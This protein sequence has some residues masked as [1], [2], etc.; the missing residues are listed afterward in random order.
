MRFFYLH[1]VHDELEEPSQGAAFLLYTRI[2]FSTGSEKSSSTSQ[3]ANSSPSSSSSPTRN[4]QPSS[5]ILQESMEAFL[6][7][8]GAELRHPEGKV[9]FQK[10]S[11]GEKHTHR[12]KIQVEGLSVGS[13]QPMLPAGQ[14]D[15]GP[16]K[17]HI[18]PEPR[19]RLSGN[20]SGSF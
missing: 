2:H 11:R 10:H 7:N 1:V 8:R 14:L 20:M 17:H 16:K 13:G 9:R 4:F 19:S 5:E 18:M 15:K 3:H 12:S 6:F